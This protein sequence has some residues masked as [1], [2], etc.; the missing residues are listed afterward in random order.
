MTPRRSSRGL[1]QARRRGGGRGPAAGPASTAATM[2][3]VGVNRYRLENETPVDIRE[4]DNRKVRDEQAAVALPR[5]AA[6]AIPM[7]SP[8]RLSH[9]IR[10]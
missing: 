5:S 2:T 8:P 6:S 9:E 1:A 4:I 3:V 7:P 10:C